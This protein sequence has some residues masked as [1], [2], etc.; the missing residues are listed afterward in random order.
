MN[1][2]ASHFLHPGIAIGGVALL[3]VPLIIHLINRLR[4]RRVRFAAMEFLLQSQ[5]RNR[6]RLL[7]EQ[8]L[9]LLVR[10]VIVAALLLLL[11]R[12]TLDPQQMSFFRGAM[13]HQLV[14]LDDSGSTQER[15]EETSAFR[16]GV[17]AV[18]QLLSDGAARPLTQRFTLLRLSK[19]NE[20]VALQR[21]IDEAFVSEMALKLDPSVMTPSHQ[22][23]GLLSGLQAVTSML[24]DDRTVVHRVTVIS[25]FREND[26]KD[27]KALQSALQEL[28]AVSSGIQLVRTTAKAQPNLAVT[29]LSGATQIATAGVPLRL[30]VGVSNLGDDPVTEVRLSLADDGVRLPLAAYFERI[31]PKTTAY[32]DVDVRLMTVGAHRLSASLEADALAAD[33]VRY[34]SVITRPSL[35]VLVIDGGDTGQ[36]GSYVI[37]ALAADAASTG[38]SATLDSLDGLRR[39]NLTE[40]AVLYL[41]D[42]P[43]LPADAIEFV[44]QYV[45]DGGGL[46]WSLG[47]NVR[48]EFY[49]ESLYKSGQGL[50]PV[51]LDRNPVELLADPNSAEADLRPADHPLF[52]IFQGDDNPF[53]TSVHI[54]QAW[55]P[56]VEWD[57]SDRRRQ[58]GCT[59]LAQLRT[60]SP[61][62]VEKAFGAGRVMACLSTFDPLW[63]DWARNP[64]FVVF[65]L[66]VLQSLA[67]RDNVI[68][69][70]V[71]GEPLR[72]ELNPALWTER[73]EITL[74]DSAG[75]QVVR[76]QAAPEGSDAGPQ[77]SVP[78]GSG[79]DVAAP[80]G[81]ATDGVGTSLAETP[82]GQAAATRQPGDGAAPA[83]GGR[84]AS[85]DADGDAADP[86]MLVAMYRDTDVPGI[87]GVQTWNQSQQA[88]VQLFAYNF[89]ESESQ[90][91]L[92]SASDLKQRVAGVPGLVIHDAGRWQLST[93]GDEVGSEVRQML[94]LCLAGLLLFEQ[95]WAYRMSFH[96]PSR[97]AKGMRS[98]VG[99]TAR[100][101]QPAWAAR[102]NAMDVAGGDRD[103][104]AMTGQPSSQLT[105]N[106]VSE[107][108]VEQPGRGVS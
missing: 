43:E 27:A 45:Q 6:R 69:T 14:L 103:A 31:D 87:Y 4:F 55:V 7:M 83:T 18:Q 71:S 48:P 86:V 106:G 108:M 97:A 46:V 57:R 56:P 8:W 22:G 1:W 75:G 100:P 98:L 59:T 79:V 85:A 64:S 65:Q 101:V 21:V 23:P 50:F 58:D 60:G 41:L 13:V 73:V 95:W 88:N 89:P 84:L 76:L 17:K 94:L 38:V 19:L 54:Q 52:A 42:V 26:W 62:L 91:T 11:A 32:Q 63:N 82:A 16:D 28:S 44:E 37:D 25:D 61:F 66:E 107:S 99:R 53:L 3:A 78:A 20:P 77:G 67:R 104:V 34:L 90:L 39:R 102:R 80:G 36:A 81:A 70:R 49:T 35:P 40:F 12:W 33:N 47:P 72:L 30:K 29:E 92:I 10:T 51:P 93:A 15:W 5:E 2:L 96:P 24:K 74:P 9:L 68:A 105:A